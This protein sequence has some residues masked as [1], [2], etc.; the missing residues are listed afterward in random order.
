MSTRETY[1]RFATCVSDIGDLYRGERCD[2]CKEVHL[3]KMGA[4][5][6]V[7][8]S[9]RIMRRSDMFEVNLYKCDKCQEFVT[10]RR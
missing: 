7:N 5:C 8:S 10:Q 6:Y 2:T 1:A 4:T 3:M 9:L